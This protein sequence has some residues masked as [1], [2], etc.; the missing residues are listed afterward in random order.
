MFREILNDYPEYAANPYFDADPSDPS[1]ANYN[2]GTQRDIRKYYE[3]A[4]ALAAGK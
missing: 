3:R 4:K 2:D 1:A